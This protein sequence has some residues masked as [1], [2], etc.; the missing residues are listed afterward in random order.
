M[1]LPVARLGRRIRLMYDNRPATRRTVPLSIV[2]LVAIL[3][4]GIT[5]SVYPAPTRVAAANAIQ[6]ENANPGDPSWDNF[7][8]VGQQDAVSGYASSISVNH[9]NPIDFYVTTTASS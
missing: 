1:F 8:S 7:A 9:G 6:T 4:A 5:S 3:L 2:A